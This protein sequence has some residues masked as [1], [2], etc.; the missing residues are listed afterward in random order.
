VEKFGLTPKYYYYSNYRYNGIIYYGRKGNFRI[1]Q[2]TIIKDKNYLDIHFF[3][4]SKK[5]VKTVKIKDEKSF[6]EGLQVIKE[7]LKKQSKKNE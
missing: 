1:F 6:S 7:I 5:K 4:K 2:I 3:S